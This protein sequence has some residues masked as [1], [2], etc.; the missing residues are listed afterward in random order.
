MPG[1][2]D[3]AMRRIPAVILCLLG[4]IYCLPAHAQDGADQIIEHYEE[5]REYSL[6][7]LNELRAENGLPSVRL[8]ALSSELA[9]R[10]ARDM[11]ENGYFSHWDREGRKPT[12]RYNLA[13]GMH[14]L[15]EN[16]FFS[17]YQRGD[18]RSFIDEAMQALAESRGHRATML[19]PSYTDVGLGLAVEGSRFYLVQEF[20]CRAGGDYSCPL[21][22]YVGDVVNFS[23][24]FDNNR[25]QLN[26]VV[27]RHEGLP[28]TRESSWLNGT[29]SYSDGDTM[30]AV[31]TPH[32][33][34]RFNVDT[35]YDIRV[36]A[37]GRFDCNLLLDYKAKPGTY[38]AILVLHDSQSG[39]EV[40]AAA[41]ALEVLK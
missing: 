18:W 36:D 35:Y 14:G 33:D 13:G 8:E 9:L 12:R 30:F 20:I 2:L 31:Y 23:G 5:A 28:E 34:R 11:A 19:D 7:L 40:K 6:D 10:H 26:Y 21:K 41:V 17:E 25:Y 24:R 15:G 16:I 38:Y 4:I 32:T 27:L 29:G 3:C 22:A 37:Q 39:S 1:M